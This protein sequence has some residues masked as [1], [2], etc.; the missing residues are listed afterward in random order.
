MPFRLA[1]SPRLGQPLGEPPR[2]PLA[3]AQPCGRQSP[4][5]CGGF[6][7]KIPPLSRFRVEGEAR[8]ALPTWKREPRQARKGAT[9]ARKRVAGPSSIQRSPPVSPFAEVQLV[10]ARELRKS[11]RSVKG[12]VLAALSIAGGAGVSMLFA[13]L[14]RT[15]AREAAARASTRTTL[16]SSSSRKL[17]RAGDGHAPRRLPVL[18]LDDAHRHAVARAAARRAPR[19]RRR[20]RR[21][22]APHGALLDGPRPPQLVHARQ[23]LRRVAR[24]SSP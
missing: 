24:R 1:E 6:G 17:V 10:T 22:A 23:V 7:L 19:L 21:A 5:R 13:W 12:I 15:S 8:A 4:R 11:F 20:V 16:R 9:V 18:A 2:R 14:E 3:A